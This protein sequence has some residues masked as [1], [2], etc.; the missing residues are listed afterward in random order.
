MYL[1]TMFYALFSFLRSIWLY[2]LGSIFH[3]ETPTPKPVKYSPP[4]LL[5]MELE[6]EEKKKQRFL[7]SFEKNEAG[8]SSNIDPV[9]YDKKKLAD[10]LS[11]E[12]N[13]LEKAWK[14]RVLI[15]TTPRGNIIMYYDPFKQAFSYYSDTT[16]MPYALTNAVAMKYVLV[17]KCRD[18]FLDDSIVPKEH[19]SSLGAKDE[20][21]ATKKPK[22][23]KASG[24]FIKP[25]TYH[26]VSSKTEVAEKITNRFV[27]LGKTRNY[28]M[29]PAKVKVN[30]NNGFSTT[31]LSFKKLSYSDYKQQQNP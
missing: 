1:V 27:H 4:S 8:H 26:Q 9:F 28:M 2:W 17:Y 22:E 24:P 19:L 18:F 15:E 20:D 3:R 5:Q 12:S 14:R 6:Y 25:K 7:Q 16:S 23:F 31:L 21:P 30:E 13:E 10:I 29:L 11:T